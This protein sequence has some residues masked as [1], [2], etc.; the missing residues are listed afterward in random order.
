MGLIK[1]FRSAGALT[2]TGL[3]AVA[4]ITL[5]LV[6]LEV[7]TGLLTLLLSSFIW[8]PGMLTVGIGFLT[9]AILM[10][11]P[12]WL[13]ILL[14]VLLAR[15]YDPLNKGSTIPDTAVTAFKALKK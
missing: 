1:K 3:I 5:P 11:T 8:A 13:P 6:P 2:Q 12:I 14:I 15:E 4:V 10:Y 9:V 7:I